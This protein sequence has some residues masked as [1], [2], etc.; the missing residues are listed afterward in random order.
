M[1]SLACAFVDAA[2]GRDAANILR[3]P[4]TRVG[5]SV[6]GRLS[7]WDARRPMWICIPGLTS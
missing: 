3:D 7:L 6:H 5:R 1:E 4:L 2:Q